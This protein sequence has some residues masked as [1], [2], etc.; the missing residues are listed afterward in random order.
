M[1]EPYEVKVSRAVLGGLG[2]GNIPRLPDVRQEVAFIY[3][4]A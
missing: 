3:S 2:D 4:W 1:L